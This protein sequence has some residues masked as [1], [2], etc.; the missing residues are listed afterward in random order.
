[1]KENEKYYLDPDTQE[2]LKL[3][4]RVHL[5]MP[6]THDGQVEIEA[7]TEEEA[8]RL[9]LNMDWTEVDWECLDT[10]D[11][12]SIEV[13][14]VECDEPPAGA[15]LASQSSSAADIGALFED[16]SASE[17]AGHSRER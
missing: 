6:A 15:V 11:R 1:M 10:G 13:F 3:R 8:V 17:D 5:I 14:D 4:Y 16:V 12:H 9:A 2:R 7:Y